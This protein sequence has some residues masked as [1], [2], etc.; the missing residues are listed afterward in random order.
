VR[1][2]NGAWHFVGLTAAHSSESFEFISDACAAYDRVLRVPAGIAYDLTALPFAGDVDPTCSALHRASY[3][4]NAAL[5]RRVFECGGEAV[6]NL[7]QCDPLLVGL[8]E[9][10]PLHFAT[11]S[12]HPSIADVVGLLLAHGARPDYSDAASGQTALYNAVRNGHA[13]ACRLLLQR[14][15][16][17]AASP[18]VPSPL[19]LALGPH[20]L[21]PLPH[22]AARLRDQE[23]DPD[24]IE[25]ILQHGARHDALDVECALLVAQSKY[26]PDRY[27]APLAGPDPRYV[28]RHSAWWTA[29]EGGLLLDEERRTATRECI[30]AH[31]AWLRSH[32][33]RMAKLRATVRVLQYFRFYLSV[34]RLMA[35]TRAAPYKK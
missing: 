12:P 15:P 13:G 6:V 10:P 5:V 3:F 9:W 33:Q 7:A 26:D 18:S 35:E 24:V 22:D 34:Q 31:G 21:H 14:V 32:P 20:W 1:R 23:V 8:V 27:P 19:L 4:G 2:V 25:A 16:M 17:L 30:A 29:Q 11:A 28:E